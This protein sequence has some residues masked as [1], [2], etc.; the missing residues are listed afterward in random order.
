M[1]FVYGHR[2]ALEREQLA[3]GPWLRGTRP[4]ES[5]EILSILVRPQFPEEYLAPYVFTKGRFFSDPAL[6]VDALSY[7]ITLPDVTLEYTPLTTTAYELSLEPLTYALTLSDVT[8]VGPTIWI[9]IPK[10][11]S[12][13]E[14]IPKVSN[15]WEDL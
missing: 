1:A 6:T 11:S 13:W 3:A 4:L 14:D 5:T 8:L 2:Y 10:L 9:D 12:L 7:S 15:T